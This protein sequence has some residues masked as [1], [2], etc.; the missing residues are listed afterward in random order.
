MSNYFKRCMSALSAALVSAVVL[1]GCSQPDSFSAQVTFESLPTQNI[2]IYVYNPDAIIYRSV[3]AI[4]GTLSFEASAPELTMVE[5]YSRTGRF[6]GRFPVKNGD[7][8]RINLTSSG[9]MT[10]K[11]DKAAENYAALL[12]SIDSS[13]AGD[14]CAKVVQFIEKN[15]SDPISPLVLTYL[16]D[17]A[18]D[19]ATGLRLATHMRDNGHDTPAMAD[20]IATL[21]SSG[22]AAVK[23]LEPVMLM[24]P[25]DT[26]ATLDFKSA[27][28][29]MVY[30]ASRERV[31]D[32]LAN[33]L[34]IPARL[35][36]A[37]VR[38]AFDTVMWGNMRKAY[39]KFTPDFYWAPS[40]AATPGLDRFNVTSLPWVSLV[41]SAANEIYRGPSADRAVAIADSLLKADR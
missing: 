18:G 13:V 12:A 33:S 2:E 1:C 14:T 38:T 25:G 9:A 8:I 17:L 5:M 36:V 11:G 16:F 3:A 6:L 21:S 31:A 39:R 40:G 29:T 19:P 7:D 23:H 24:V 30:F 10:A 41:D 34:D 22:G 35:H 4:D 37:V 32:S 26:V 28:Y 15:P 27:P 20:F